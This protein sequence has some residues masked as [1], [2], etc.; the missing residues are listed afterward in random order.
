MAEGGRHVGNWG[1]VL[2]AEGIASVNRKSRTVPPVFQNCEEAIL[3]GP[4]SKRE[5]NKDEVR[6]VAGRG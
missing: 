1:R 3:A 5:R 6:E 4:A 2:Q